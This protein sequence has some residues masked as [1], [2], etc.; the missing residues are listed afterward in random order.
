MFFFI[1]S[2]KSKHLQ[3]LKLISLQE[4]ALTLKAL[5]FWIIVS[6]FAIIY[7][8]TFLKTSVLNLVSTLRIG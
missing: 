6:I 4:L 7:N 2:H 1:A 8:K 5:T 3:A